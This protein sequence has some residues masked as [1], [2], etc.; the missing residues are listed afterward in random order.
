MF[1]KNLLFLENY[2]KIIKILNKILNFAKESRGQPR[3]MAMFL[4]VKNLF[5][6]AKQTKR[7]IF[8]VQYLNKTC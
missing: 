4:P 6:F 5:P 2:R 1:H 7:F 8:L 3:K